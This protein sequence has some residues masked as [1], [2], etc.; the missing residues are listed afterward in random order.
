MNLKVF[1]AKTLISSDETTFI[2]Q[3]IKELRYKFS[4]L[5]ETFRK[6]KSRQ[7]LKYTE[8]FFQF[9]KCELF[10]WL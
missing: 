2:K 4:K 8:I 5:S 3:E 7:F 10:P 6:I 1:R 9:I